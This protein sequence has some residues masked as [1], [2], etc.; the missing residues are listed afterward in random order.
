MVG[1]GE[2]LAAAVIKEVVRK[3][4]GVL[5][6]SVQGQVQRIRS[7]KED[8]NDIK[9]TLESIKA[10]MAD[11]EKR[12]ITDESARLW[13]KRLKHA[14]YDISDMFDEFQHGS[15]PDQQQDPSWFKIILSGGMAKKMK[16]MNKRLKQIT[17]QSKSYGIGW[18][19]SEPKIDA[20]DDQETTSFSSSV[21]VG[22]RVEK[23]AVINILLS[24]N[25][26]VFSTNS[27]SQEISHCTVIH[28][29][30][31]VGKTELA[32]LVFNDERIQEAFPQRAWVSLHQ[33]WHEKEI[34]R[35]IISIIE[36]IPCN[37]E[38]L[39]S[40]YQRLKNVLLSRCLIILDNLW[41]S[42]HLT[43]LQGILGSNVSILV[44][45]RREIRLNIPKATLFPLDPLSDRLSF[46]LVKQVASSYF[47]EG[48][49]PKIAMEEIV[50]MCRGV[51]LALKCVASLLKPERS[52]N[53]LLSLIK[54]IFPPKSDYGT[55]DIRQAVLASL[56]LTY[57]LMTP[58]LNLCFAYCA[59]FAKGYEID[60]EDLCH[61][62]IAL[63]LTEKMCAED[64]VRDLLEMSFLQDSEPPAI[65]KSSS[66][67][68]S[69]LKM[70]D[71][72]HDLAKLVAD[73]E[74]VV[75]NEED[76][77]Y[78]PYPP[79][80]AMIFSCKLEN[81]HKNNL[82]TRL[83]ALH[84]KD[85]KGLKFKWNNCSFVK[86]L[87]ILDISGLCSE[88][89]P[90]S[91]GNMMQLRYLNAS[92][93]QCEVLPKTIGTLSK[94][95]YLNLHGSRI[96]ALPD[97][98][99][100]L[101]QLMHLDIS[102]CVHLQTL[103]N[104]FCNFERLYFL[105]LKNCSRLSSLPDNLAKLKNLEKLNLSGCSC[106][107]TLPKSLGGLD[108][109]RQLDLS[110]CK[111]LTM[112]PK[113]FISLT[114]LQYLNISSCSELDIPVDDL[115]KLTK[116]NYIDMSSCPKLLGLPQEFC[117]LKHL[118]TL[119]L[120]DCSKLANLPEELGQM[121]SIKFILLDGCAESVRKP[122]L[123][124]RL[125]AGLQSLPAFVVETNV[126]SIRSNISQLEQEKFSELELYRLENIR[127]V[128]E[129][130]ALK[131]PDRSGLRS[132][133]LMWTINVERFV[134]D[135][136]LLQALEPHEN[137]NK[138]RMQGYMGKRFPKWKLELGSSRQG[139]LHEVGLM[140]FPMCNT[141]PQL[142]QLA[143]LKKLHLSRMPKIRRLGRE[144]SDSTGG[145]RNLQIFTLE[146]MKNLEE[147]CT[148]MT[149]ATGQRKQDGFM[150][151]ALQELNIYHCPLL[152]MNPCPPR[153]IDNWEV[154]ASKVSAQLLLQKEE[155]MQSLADYMGLQ[156]P[157]AYTTELQVSGSSSSSPLLPT[158]GW[159]FNG[160]LITLKDLTS[161]CCSLIDKLLDKGN[162]MQFL[163]NL[164]I[165]G[166]K[167]TNSLL[168]EVE[169][170]AYRTRSS[171]AKS[172]PDW[173]PQ[174]P[175]INR[176]SP[177]FIVTGYAS[178]GVD[179]WIDKVT[180]FLGNLIRINMEDLPLCD[181]LPPLGQ[182]P[183]LQ[184][185]RLKGMPKIKSIDRNFCGSHPSSN[186]L[187]FLRL[188]R[189]VLN[190]MP[191]L[192]EWVTKVSGTSDPCGQEEFMFPNLVKLTIWNCPK[193]KL[194]PCPP[195]A[196]EWDINNSDQVIASNYD[197]NSGGDLA[198]MLQVLL[199]KVPPNDWK[200][201]S[202]P[203][204]DPKLGY[205]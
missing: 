160:S 34:A 14:A 70:H 111:K 94:L 177:H 9:M 29:L 168:E 90:S 101:G 73:D 31:G 127:T 172:W 188:T 110:G 38:I 57:N 86:C 89:L 189:F 87:R 143:N 6:A 67:V 123:Q 91:I 186:A 136:A 171:L 190:G 157:F 198:T 72:V 71:L 174:L 27:Y 61:Q 154:R 35:A 81:L 159:K 152:T 196:M 21:I 7:F 141:L 146:Y 66:G 16:K 5:Q 175:S 138:F 128:D 204:W 102:D 129:A 88:K 118:H 40:I 59:I 69:K 84:I 173:F 191:N 56:K 42:G 75:I 76:K 121:E 104:S 50:K 63:G 149:S 105:S 100:K 13:L 203:P 48:D 17:E 202:S 82:L 26:K 54:A 12:S 119:N 65:T 80:Y 68:L 1:I 201:L 97:S 85:S 134:E 193:L 39:E 166:I 2:M 8:L 183:M 33:N 137:L 117:R 15:P 41:D 10:A 74:L 23:Q 194:K 125:G 60:R 20:V 164:E 98:V 28:G 114:G 145:L 178:C 140:H 120:S 139:Q 124:Y 148:T 151:P 47:L 130:K 108:S 156:C 25:N 103:P 170:V 107:H 99:T 22:R 24:S 109:L 135:E 49:I 126:G 200:L 30:A 95:Q 133:G 155:V 93:I 3:L 180:S 147:W 18:V 92:G 165:S 205:C 195:R 122:I 4:P 77:V 64:S 163:V 142:G 79:R 112:L 187:F 55:T 161:D 46:D 185:L 43:K 199:C 96:S 19:S 58:S 113:S 153:S 52:V 176:A 45:S 78:A 106:L 115:T 182:L 11:A 36:G 62:W 162:S 197:I 184:E 83:K 131:M 179:G 44:T 32:K 192:E 150:F 181:R 144:L 169:S 53:E 51:P 116:L 167:D 132:L 37:L 158:D